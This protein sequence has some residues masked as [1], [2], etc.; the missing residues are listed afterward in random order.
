MN[1]TD[2]LRQL[3]DIL[4]EMHIDTQFLKYEKQNQ[5][6]NK[7]LSAILDECPILTKSILP[8]DRTG[9]LAGFTG[10]QK[11]S[12]FV[13]CFMIDSVSIDGYYYF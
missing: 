6:S 11:Y 3:K 8:E 9:I 4:F 10:K 7:L 1:V 5:Q 12:T 13:E 2:D